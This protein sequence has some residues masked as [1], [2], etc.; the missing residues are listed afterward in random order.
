LYSLQA[1]KQKFCSSE[2][3]VC[4]LSVQKILYPFKSFE[5]F[6][7]LFKLP[8]KPVT[9]MAYNSLLFETLNFFGEFFI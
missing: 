3:T 8:E 2:K 5:A 4:S 7:V 9:V 1:I 6:G